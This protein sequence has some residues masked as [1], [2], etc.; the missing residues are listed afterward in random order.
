MTDISK[1]RPLSTTIISVLMVIWLT[2]PV[3]LQVSSSIFLQKRTFGTHFLGLSRQW[4]PKH[5]QNKSTQWWFV[6]GDVLK[7]KTA[8]SITIPQ[9][10]ST[11]SFAHFT[12]TEKHEGIFT[13]NR[14]RHVAFGTQFHCQLNRRLFHSVSQSFDF[15]RTDSIWWTSRWLCQLRHSHGF[16]CTSAYVTVVLTSNSW[17]LL[18]SKVILMN[19]NK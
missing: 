16:Y 19:I 4:Q 12:F 11:K 7:H 3:P 17:L 8:L 14:A 18:F 5:P 1:L 15:L 9:L 6:T 10:K 13:T 2:W